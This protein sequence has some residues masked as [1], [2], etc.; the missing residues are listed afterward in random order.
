MFS[1]VVVKSVSN[2]GVYCVPCSVCAEFLR[3]LHKR[4]FYV[5][6]SWKLGTLDWFWSDFV[7]DVLACSPRMCYTVI[8]ED[9]KYVFL[10]L[11]TRGSDWVTAP[12][13]WCTHISW[14]VILDVLPYHTFQRSSVWAQWR[15]VERCHYYSL[16]I[17]VNKGQW[18]H[19]AFGC[20]VK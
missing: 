16:Q 3:W 11:K 2:C 19:L 17:F 4:G 5:V 18:V 9:R 1:S 13:V 6:S 20:N 10:N 12:E 15:T 7:S 14:P 8:R